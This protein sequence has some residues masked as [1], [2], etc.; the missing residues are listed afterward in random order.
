MPPGSITNRTV[1]HQG[2]FAGEEVV[3][4]DAPVD[5]LIGGLIAVACLDVGADRHRAGFACARFSLLPSAGPSAGMIVEA[6]TVTRFA[7]WCYGSY[8]G[9]LAK[10]EAPKKVF[11]PDVMERAKATDESRDP[12][13]PAAAPATRFATREHLVFARCPLGIARRGRGVSSS[14]AVDVGRRSSSPGVA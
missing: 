12:S 13:S 1:L 8:T 9:V 4:R 10:R 7:R 6:Q 3:E 14:P 2:D 11:T 5:E